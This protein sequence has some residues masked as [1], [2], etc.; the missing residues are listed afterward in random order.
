MSEPKC[1]SPEELGA[2]VEGQIAP[3]RSEEIDIHLHACEECHET[4][5]RLNVAEDEL[6]AN[7]RA[8]SP[9]EFV[10]ETECEDALKQAIVVSGETGAVADEPT[11]LNAPRSGDTAPAPTV[12]PLGV[13]REYQL[14]EKLGQGGMGAVYK[15]RHAKLGKIV[16]I[17][18]LPQDRMQSP[19]AVARFERE[20]RA[21]GSLSHPNI[22]GASDAG[23][24][25]GKHYLVMEYVEGTDL[26]DLVK[27]QGPLAPTDACELIRQAALGLQH[28]HE[29]GLVH[30]DIKP[31]NLMLTKQGVVKILDLGLA[32]L[33][34][35]QLE[36][37][38]ELTS[39][40]QIMGTVDY[41][42]PEQGTNTHSVDIRADLYSLGATLYKLLSGRV[43]F[44]NERNNSVMQRLMALANETPVSVAEHRSDVPEGLAKIVT[45]LL[46]KQ[47]AERYQT[48]AD[49]AKALAP[50]CAGHELWRLAGGPEGSVPTMPQPRTRSEQP[51]PAR[52]PRIAGGAEH[53]TPP[54]RKRRAWAWGAFSAVLLAGVIVITTAK[55]TVTID[56]PEGQADNVVV[57][58]V[59]GGE[60]VQVLDKANQW[61]VSV[62]GGEYELQLKAGDSELSLRDNRV[63]VSRFGTTRAEIVYTPRPPLPEHV[64]VPWHG[65]PA[66]APAPAIAPFDAAQARQHQEAWA[67]YLKVPV[68]YTNSIGMKFVLIPPGEFLMGS[69]AEEADHAFELAKDHALS[70]IRE[71]AQS[72]SPQHRVILTQP[73]FLCVTEVTQG[74]YQTVMDGNPSRFSSTGTKPELAA[75]VEGLET[76][77]HPVENVSWNDAAEFCARLSRRDALQPHYFRSGEVVTFLQGS[78]YQL[79]TEAEWEFACRGGSTTLFWIGDE[80]DDLDR[81]A[82]YGKNSSGRTHP[83]GELP[84]NPFGLHDVHGNVGEWVRDWWRQAYYAEFA[85]QAAIDPSGPVSESRRIFRGGNWLDVNFSCRS[86]CRQANRPGSSDE[87]YGFRVSLSVDSV[88]E[89]TQRDKN[90]PGNRNFAGWHG[91]PADAPPPAIAPFDAAQARKHQE[92]WSAYLKVPVEYTNSIGMKFVLIPPGEFIMGSTPEQIAAALKDAGEDTHWQ[93][94]IKS[95]APQHK[96]ILTQPIYLGMNEVTQAEYENVMGVNP[97]YFAPTGMGKEA[98]AGL[99]TADHPVE[100]VSWNDAAEFCAKLSKQEKLKPFYFRAGE[101]ITPLDGTGYRLPSEAEWEFACRAG[102]TTRFWSGDEDNDLVSAGWFGSNSGGRTHAVG[103]LKSNPFGLFDMHGNVWELVQDGW[104]AN[105]YGQFPEQPVIDPNSPFFSNF[106]R[107]IRGGNWIGA[108]SYCRSSDRSPSDSSTRVSLVGFRVSLP[109]DAVRELLKAQP[110]PNEIVNTGWHNWPAD[111]PAPAIAPFD[112]AQARKHQEAWAAYLKV[113]VEY[114]NSIGMKFMLIP[115]G[116]FI[117]GSTPEEIEAALKVAG[118]DKYWQDRIKSEAPQHKV[119]LTQ[120]IY[121]GLNEVTQEEY[122][123]VM[124]VNP[125]HFA[126]LGMGK[127]AVAGLETAKHPVETVSWHDAAEFCAKLSNQEK[128]KLF[129]FRS[130]ETITPLDGTG[131]R[132][133]SEAEWEFACRAG[134]ATKYWIGD[135]DEDLMR[136]GLFG[137]NSGGRTH[138]VGELKANPFGLSDIHGNVC[139]WV[140]DGWDAT[141][142]GQ[143]QDKPAINPNRPF[144]AGSQRVLRG[145]NWYC[146]ASRC[147]SSS[148]FAQGPPHRGSTIGFRVVLTADA[149]KQVLAEMPATMIHQAAGWHGWPADAPAPAVAPFDAAQ[150]R[151]H[152][153]EWA[154]YLNVPVEYTNSIGMKFVLIPPGEFLMGSTPE[155]IESALGDIDANNAHWLAC[156]KSEA[157]Q[158]KVILTQPVY[159]GTREVTQAEYEQLLGT[160]PSSFAPTGPGSASVAGL[161]PR[162]H[163]VEM[164]S[165]NDAVQFC[166]KLSEREKLEPSYLQTGEKIAPR[167]GRGYRLPSEAEWEGACRAGTTTRFWVGD[168]ADSLP[169]AGWFQD[170]SGGRTHATGELKA[171][172]YGLFDMHG[173]VWEWV[174]DAWA[175]DFYGR[176]QELPAIDPSCEHSFELLRVVRGGDWAYAATRSRASSRLANAP[177][178]RSQHFGF[179]VALPLDAVRGAGQAE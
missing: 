38:G 3:P 169:L 123:K 127:E 22:V 29:H 120:P 94:C 129:Y 136:S 164:V 114:T 56:I 73:F 93:E 121:L 63:I 128:L 79:P 104:N 177:Q 158:H 126:P 160:T 32:L 64:G 20:M 65:W 11:F 36:S 41:M 137:G 146:T 74:Q 62:S 51:A 113:P 122:E 82:W 26:A 170:N 175:P 86:S 89:L 1:P 116:E 17:K 90:P 61:T 139:E 49:L 144:S 115:P 143:F 33:G 100:M 109:V 25:E 48:P 59:S 47:P 39:T 96:V 165:W 167:V 132:L 176:F 27:A 155:E 46:S 23:E 15:A 71:L 98:V 4:L 21:V 118:E 159:L 111:A 163:P 156:L 6:T 101:T 161:D 140:Q 141:Y 88:R 75:K 52:Q 133:P 135:Q 50:F 91:W 66:D 14:L 85:Q 166:L 12:P 171:N 72:E 43:P 134:T 78:G 152:Q 18:V 87:R 150:A 145:G 34:E 44:Q 5:D 16:A 131:Y 147:R 30:R 173:N 162:N 103:E 77:D 81:V 54:A 153:E 69:T 10:D 58:V 99:E 2:Y 68:E 102:T 8:A 40:G 67:A 35:G 151:K 24:F 37:A 19:D 31:S 179:R 105:W 112:A 107:V 119:I 130:G 7:L 42:A 154:A 157:P 124:G 9:M 117:M 76:A 80:S 138:A 13:L 178:Y 55:G 83:V 45:R 108:A 148:R 97:S 70:L 53:G 92:A 172:P 84:A 60:V 95:E 110:Q 125:S 174:Q 168:K 149:V 28:V 57:N 106:Q 142:Y